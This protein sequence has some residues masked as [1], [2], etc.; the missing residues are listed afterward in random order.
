MSQCLLL[1]PERAGD[2][3]PDTGVLA[4]RLRDIGLTGHSFA[5]DGTR[6]WLTGAAFPSLISFLG[7]A[8]DLRLEPPDTPADTWGE[9][10][11]SFCH[12]WISPVSPMP[13]LWIGEQTRAPGCPDCG[14][15]LPLATDGLARLGC[16][17]CG[18]SWP[19]AGFH[20]RR[21]AAV[22][23]QFVAVYGV[24]P[25]EAVPT[26]ELLEALRQIGGFGWQ[27]AYLLGTPCPA[28]AGHD[29][30]DHARPGPGARPGG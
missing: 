14:A 8:P 11:D 25:A 6:R 23:R 28:A 7:C 20:W 3:L 24:Y 19:A 12:V 17:A 29:A 15:T 4:T 10:L 2:A 30:T 21:R 9:Q 22:C 1:H 18:R 5:P 27:Y 13:R 16:P 26:G